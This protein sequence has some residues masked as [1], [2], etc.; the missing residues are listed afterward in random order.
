MFC[1]RCSVFRHILVCKFK[2]NNHSKN[3]SATIWNGVIGIAWPGAASPQPL[4]GCNLNLQ[5]SSEVSV[6]LTF[7]S[8]LYV[9]L[10]SCLCNYRSSAIAVDTEGEK[11]NVV[12]SHKISSRKCHELKALTGLIEKVVMLLDC[13]VVVLAWGFVV[14]T[15]RFVSFVCSN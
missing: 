7:S 1:G 4:R 9:I 2:T 11:R 13:M 15:W 5:F 12:E 14:V 8:A 10:S 3:L 6:A